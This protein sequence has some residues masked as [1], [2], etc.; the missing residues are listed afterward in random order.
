MFTRAIVRT[1]CRAMVNGLSSADLG[2]PD[3]AKALEQH[4]DYVQ[5]LEECGLRVT[6]LPADED[7]P[8]STFSRLN[9]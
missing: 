3:Y 7:Y 4:A 2:L 6:V 8:D 1:P 9:T 5:A